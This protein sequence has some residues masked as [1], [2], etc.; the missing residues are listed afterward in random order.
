MDRRAWS[1][2]VAVILV[3]FG[4]L[5]VVLTFFL[6]R[7]QKTRTE[8]EEVALPAHE[9]ADDI[10]LELALEVAEARG[11]LVTGR[12]EHR[13]EAQHARRAVLRALN[14]IDPMAEALGPAVVNRLDEVRRAEAVNAAATSQL[15]DRTPPSA[16][17]TGSLVAQ[18]AVLTRVFEA[19]ERL[20]DVI[21]Q[22]ADERRQRQMEAV[23]QQELVVTTLLVLLALVSVLA[24]VWLGRRV[25]TLAGLLER[26]VSANGF[27]WT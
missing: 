17:P 27:Q 23:R 4:T 13:R 16:D 10:E 3:C 7:A 24:V 25:H 8:I 2:A 5:L 21:E 26:R 14:D 15:L 1:L 9:R 19:T 11:Y 22:A 6:R 20:S 12:E 18:Q